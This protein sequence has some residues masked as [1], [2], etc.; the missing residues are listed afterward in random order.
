[1]DFLKARQFSKKTFAIF[2]ALILSA[3]AAPYTQP[4]DIVL[5]PRDPENAI[6]YFIRSQSDTTV[7][8][9]KTEERDLGT[10]APNIYMAVRLSPGKHKFFTKPPVL[11]FTDQ[12]VA[13]PL[14]LTVQ[15]NEISFYYL[16]GD[17][18]RKQIFFFGKTPV[19]QQQN[20]LAGRE[21]KE[22][23]EH[24]ARRYMGSAILVKGKT[25]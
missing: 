15:A 3:C 25:N 21:W 10:M 7:I 20:L 2:S 16:T 12:D 9:L 22:V 11:L 19:V 8:T 18:K 14:E 23:T 6:I 1:M 4:D 24:D 13:P 17:P 5:L